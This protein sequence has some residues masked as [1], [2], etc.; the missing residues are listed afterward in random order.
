M[1]VQ[2]KKGLLDTVLLASL[3]KEDSYGYRIVQEVSQVIPIS[4]ST[5]YP[6]L[7]RLENTGSLR[8][9][10]IEYSG[11]LRKY[12][13]ITD[14]GRKKVKEFLNEWHELSNVYNFISRQFKGDFYE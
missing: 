7:R 3:A 14:T 11:R 8:T 6:I 4:E 9:Y 10:S 2:L 1:E 12:Y 5:L 13:S